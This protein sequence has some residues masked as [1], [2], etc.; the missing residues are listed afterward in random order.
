MKATNLS[1]QKREKMLNTLNE[2]KKKITDDSV[3]KDITL[4]EN[5]LNNKKYGLIWEEHQERV[6]VEL[7]TQIPAFEEVKDKKIYNNKNNN[8]NFLLEGDNLHSLY[9]LEKTHKG[10]IDVI[11][12]D[13]PYNTG[14]GDFIYNDKLLDKNDEYKHSKWLSFMKKRIDISKKLLSEKG[15][16]FISIDDNEQAQLK[17]MC[18][19]IFG[20]HNFE[21]FI[22]QKKGG[23]GNTEK[24]I[25]CLTEYILCYFKN[26]KAGI[27]NYREIQREYKYKD[28]KGKYNL[29]GLEKTNLGIYN[30]P[31]MLFEIIDKKT[32]ISF[33]PRNN[34]RWTIGK[35][36]AEDY[37]N[38]QK[39]F[40]NYKNNRVYRKRL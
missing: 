28:E 10:K 29:E 17:L 38:N 11:Y 15:V 8:Y 39:L 31:T 33:F 30:R 22:W 6:D 32:G 34:N 19:E 12:I 1:K 16:I 4:I 18:D 9:L 23:S 35:N 3:L 25:G 36:T 2:I 26:K 24:I 37:Q 13:P 7:Q 14:E 21:S 40:F 5:E 20:S 27:F